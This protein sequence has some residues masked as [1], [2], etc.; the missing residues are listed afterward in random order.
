M[1]LENIGCWTIIIGVLFVF[2]AITSL[3][4]ALIIKAPLFVFVTGII[5]LTIG[6]II[7][8]I[9]S[10]KGKRKIARKQ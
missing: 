7:Y 3:I 2:C 1:K 4:I 8:Y 5:L 9:I 6:I 10:N